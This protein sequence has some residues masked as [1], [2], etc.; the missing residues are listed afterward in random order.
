VTDAVVI[1]GAAAM[2]TGAAAPTTLLSV[3][4]LID[5][6]IGDRGTGSELVITN[7]SGAPL[8]IAVE[9]VGDITIPAAGSTLVPVSA[10]PGKTWL[11]LQA[12]STVRSEV[13]MIIVAVERSNDGPVAVGQAIGARTC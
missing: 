6:A 11:H 13:V 10:D 7:A 8:R 1:S 2:R 3:P 12:L 5:L 4:E 9:G